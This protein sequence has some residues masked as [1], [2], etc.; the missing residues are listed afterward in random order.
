MRRIMRLAGFPRFPL[1]TLP[2]PLTRARNLERALG[3][4]CPR[5]YIKRD[6]LTGIAFGGNKARKLEYVLA[7]AIRNGSTAV[8]T[9]G[10]V[11][12]NHARLTA[13]AATLAG[14]KVVLVLDARHGAEVEGNLFL[15]RLMGVDVRI[16]PE[17]P[18]RAEAVAAVIEELRSAGE[19]PYAIPTGASMPLGA[20]GY[21]AFV[22]ELTKQLF[23]IGET[24]GRLYFASGSGGTH[25]GIVVGAR[26]FSAPFVPV[27]VSDGDPA[28]AMREKWLPL[29]RATAELIGLD[30]TFDGDDF[31]IEDRFYGKGYGEPTA[32]GLDAIRLLA[33]T[34]AVFLEPVYTGKAMAALLAHI[35]EGSFA[36]DESVVFLHTGGGPSLFAFRDE[37]VGP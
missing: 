14:L 27:G 11:Q 29:L 30:A 15:D 3:P 8:V 21:V 9:E 35:R 2:T 1:T 25:S 18:A 4:G 33:R 32:D 16:V 19:V 6:D 12:S 20:I 23:E 31:V 34:E 22:L 17:A 10:S 37:L 13:A 5:I 26:A 36:A 28:A 7:D 24:P